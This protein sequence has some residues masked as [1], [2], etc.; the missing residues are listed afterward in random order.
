MKKLLFANIALLSTII[1]FN[2]C[3][4]EFSNNDPPLRPLVYTE[5][6][7]MDEEEEDPEITPP[8]NIAPEDLGHGLFQAIIAHDRS[9]Y[10]KMFVSG[11]ELSK[12][13]RMPVEKANIESEKYRRQSEVLWQLFAPDL[14]VEEPMGGLSVRLRLAEFRIGKGR[15]LAGKVAASEGDDVVQ[16]WGNELRIELRNSDK[17]FIIRVPKVVKTE[18]GWRIAQ[19]VEMDASLRIYLE[20]G[21]HLKTELLSTEHYPYPLSVGNFWKYR[22][23]QPGTPTFA[24]DDDPNAEHNFAQEQ[25]VTVSVKEIQDFQGYRIVSFDR[26]EHAAEDKMTTFSYLVTPKT[27]YPCMRD[28]K[29]HADNIGYLLGYMAR[30]TPVFVF[31]LIPKSGWSQAGQSM[32]HNRYEVRAKRTEPFQITSGTFNDVYEING[33]IEEGREERFFVPGIGIV[34][35][36]LHAGMQ[37]RKEELIQYRLIL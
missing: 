1:A 23:T 9:S 17:V 4:R 11:E 28:C 19:G 24:D 2:A 3:E 30:Q 7:P 32:S 12:L 8:I 22:L 33:S 31:P 5:L 6:P 25:T 29:F 27:I 26:E 37:S 10:E 20:S 36:N 21:M 18:N 14:S 16:H 35:R 34:Q 15:N 13:V